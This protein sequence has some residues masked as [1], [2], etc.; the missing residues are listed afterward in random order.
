MD[1]LFE[2]QNN[3]ISLRVMTIYEKAVVIKHRVAQLNNGYKSTIES[4]VNKRKLTSSYDIAMLEFDLGKLPPY[5]IM[6]KRG[7]GYTEIWR[8]E[9]FDVFPD[10]N[11]FEDINS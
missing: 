3:K 11:L 10:Q 8:H 2:D 4:E 9:D 7:N 6:R 5:E 1:Q